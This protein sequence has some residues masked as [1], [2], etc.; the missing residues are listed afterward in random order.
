M[1]IKGHALADFIAEFTYSNTTEVI[2]TANSTDAK[3]VTGVRDKENSIPTEGDAEQW[4]LYVDSA[5]NDTGFGAGMMLISPEGH[6]IHCAICFGFKASNKEAEYE[7]V[8]VG[9]CLARKLQVR[10]VKI[11][12]DS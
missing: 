9:L 10:N 8:I 2:G 4:T 11:F 7:A 6:K 3:K 12:S 1:V 5:S